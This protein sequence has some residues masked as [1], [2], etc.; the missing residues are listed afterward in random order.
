MLYIFEQL[1][2]PKGYEYTVAVLAMFIFIIFYFI[3]NQETKY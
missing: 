3:L 1:F 2:T